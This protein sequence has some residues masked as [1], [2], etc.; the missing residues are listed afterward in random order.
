MPA[1][2]LINLPINAV[3]KADYNAATDSF[4]IT[5]VVRQPTSIVLPNTGIIGE[6]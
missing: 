2:E 5:S 3:L 6:N 4:M 1:T